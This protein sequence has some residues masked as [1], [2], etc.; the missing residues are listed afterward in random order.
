MCYYVYMSRGTKSIFAIFWLIGYIV[1]A[2]FSPATLFAEELSAGVPSGALWFSK[3]PIFAG[4]TISL[5]TVV[6]NSTNYTLSGTIV[7]RDG[8]TTITKKEFIVGGNGR[9]DVIAFPWQVTEGKHSFSVAITQNELKGG[10]GG[11]QSTV[12]VGTTTSSIKRFADRDTDGDGVGN[13]TDADDD[14]DGLSDLEEKKLHTDPLNKDTDGDGIEDLTDERPLVADKKETP[15]A[16]TTQMITDRT[17]ALPAKIK[18]AIPEPILSKATP[19]LGFIEDF[20][21]SEARRGASGVDDAREEVIALSMTAS[22]TRESTK[23]TKGGWNLFVDGLQEGEVF[24]TPFAYVKLFAALVYYSLTSS[25]YIFYPFIL[26]VI[27]QVIRFILRA[28]FI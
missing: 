1:V 24:K 15:T 20:R 14:S 11:T 21:V 13:I 8:T 4:E 18:T 10:G 16:T 9:A 25:A 17:L 6:Y 2:A 22:T 3:D 26:L 12:I 23:V 28:F 7:L 19:V 5:F 27:Y